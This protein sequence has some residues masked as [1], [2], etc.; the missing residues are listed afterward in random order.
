MYKGLKVAVYNV[1][2]PEITLTR[3]DLVELINV[4]N[5]LLSNLSYTYLAICLHVSVCTCVMN[6]FAGPCPE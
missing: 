3:Q 6:L 5:H 2:K 1:D 4:C